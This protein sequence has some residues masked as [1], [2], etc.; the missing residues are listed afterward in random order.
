MESAKQISAEAWSFFKNFMT[1]EKTE[2]D[3]DDFAYGTRDAVKKYD[4][5]ESQ[6]AKSINLAFIC[7]AEDKE[8]ENK[9]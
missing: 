1:S 6:L 9:Q 2:K 7:Y 3:W 4:G 5:P 8:K